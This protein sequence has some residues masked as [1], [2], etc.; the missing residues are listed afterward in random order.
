M[1]TFRIMCV[2]FQ[3]YALNQRLARKTIRKILALEACIDFILLG[4]VII[5]TLMAKTNLSMEFCK[6][7]SRIMAMTMSQQSKEKFRLGL[8]FL[9]FNMALGTNFVCLELLIYIFLF[10]TLYNEQKNNSALTEKMKKMK[11]KKN[12]ITMWGQFMSFFVEFGTSLTLQAL[13][14]LNSGTE[15]AV[16][17]CV[18]VCFSA[19]VTLTHLISSPEMRRFYLHF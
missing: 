13:T 8:Q 6:G 18:Q 19:A 16:F 7:H 10:K 14:I 2:K 17:A 1:A 11:Q 9:T 15:T 3:N 4:N 12:A 5:G